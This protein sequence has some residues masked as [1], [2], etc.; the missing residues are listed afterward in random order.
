MS[1]LTMWMRV[2]RPLI[3]GFGRVGKKIYV[4]D[5][6]KLQAIYAR[7]KEH[8]K[9]QGWERICAQGCCRSHLARSERMQQMAT[10]LL[11]RDT[12]TVPMAHVVRARPIAASPA[13]TSRSVP[14]RLGFLM[15][16]A[17]TLLTGL[18]LFF[19]L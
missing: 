16:A 2:Q 14:A 3:Y 15:C 18:P 6:C 11:D 10:G 7:R 8:N 12:V 17:T 19:P 1:D 13:K 9:R 4:D 5:T